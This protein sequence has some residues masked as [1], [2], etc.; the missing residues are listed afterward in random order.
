MKR[1]DLKDISTKDLVAHFAQIGVAQ[2]KALLGRESATFNRLF[3]QMGEVSN[4]LRQR[5]GDQRRALLVLYSFP[6]TQVQLKAAVHTL[7]VAPVEARQQLEAI[8]AT[9]WFPQ[10]G[11]AGM[12]LTSLDRGVFRPT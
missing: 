1:V 4:E 5:E 11:D 6:N 2:D 12:L 9:H 10:A 7:A 8:A 3:K